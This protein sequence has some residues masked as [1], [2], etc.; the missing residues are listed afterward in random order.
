M[1]KSK[2]S[3]YQKINTV[4]MR[5]KA[6][7]CIVPEFVSPVA[8]WMFD[9]G[10]K[11]YSTEKIDGTNTSFVIETNSETETANIY[12]RGKTESA[13][14]EPRHKALHKTVIDKLNKACG[15]VFDLHSD[16]VIEVFGEMYGSGI[17]EPAGSKYVPDGIKFIVF[18]IKING[19][20]LLPDNVKDICYKVGLDYVPE[21]GMMTIGEAIDLVQKRFYSN[22]VKD[23]SLFAE[24]VVMKLPLGLLDRNGERIIIKVKSCDFIKY[25]AKTNQNFSI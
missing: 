22:L 6:T 25:K 24:G 12:A 14:F 7:N 9:E 21:M 11:M 1:S 19:L 8:K 18:D 5:D 16:A 23:N 15:D 10:I 2:H 17:Q 20:Y 13:F 4:F 3:F